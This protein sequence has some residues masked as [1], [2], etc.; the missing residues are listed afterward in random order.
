ML[1]DPTIYIN[2]KKI[3]GAEQKNNVEIAS[4][5][6]QTKQ[7][8]KNNGNTASEKA[9]IAVSGVQ[10]FNWNSSVNNWMD[11]ENENNRDSGTSSS[12]GMPA[13]DV[14]TSSTTSTNISIFDAFVQVIMNY[15]L[16]D[17]SRLGNPFP[18]FIGD[19]DEW[20]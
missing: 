14:P 13:S 18:Y 20:S 11:Y 8:M 6:L 7:K 17:S 1:K 19:I 9:D 15:N 10:T 5:I 12:D 16:D 3:L 2:D 4:T